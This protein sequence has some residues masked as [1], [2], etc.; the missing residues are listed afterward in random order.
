MA[1]KI[2]LGLYTGNVSNSAAIPNAVGICEN[3]VKADR[4]GGWIWSQS[5]RVDSNRNFIIHDFLHRTTAE[6]LFIIDDDMAH[7]PDMALQLASRNKPMTAGLYF[8]RSAEGN[9]APVAYRYNGEALETRRGHGKGTNATYSPV[10]KEVMEFLKSHKAPAVDS[11]VC[12]RGDTRDEY[13]PEDECVI[14]IDA[15]G[16][17][18]ILLRRDALE[19]MDEPYLIDELALNGDLTFYRNAMRKGIP[20]YLDMSTIAAHYHSSSF[21]VKT[22][23]DYTWKREYDQ[24]LMRQGKFTPSGPREPEDRPITT[25]EDTHD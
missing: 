6:F 18:C 4:W 9:H 22:F 21:S 3:L 19:Q 11:C 16:F 5:S 12:I 7:P 13:L 10:T 15:T 14:P 2:V 23:C 17:G 25:L 1:S 8:R 20:L 24:E